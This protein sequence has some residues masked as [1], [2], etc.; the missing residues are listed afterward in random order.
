MGNLLSVYAVS[1]SD[2]ELSISKVIFGEYSRLLFA[3]YD[4]VS[5]AYFMY[6]LVFDR[7][8]SPTIRTIGIE[9][10]SHALCSVKRIR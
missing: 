8:F 1:N 7:H 4:D 3:I 5:Q 6:S 10:K 9:V 2:C